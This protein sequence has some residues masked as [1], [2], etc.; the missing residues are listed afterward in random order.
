[1][2]KTIKLSLLVASATSIGIVKAIIPLSPAIAQSQAKI[3]VVT[4]DVV[5]ANSHIIEGEEGVVVIDSLLT[6]DGGSEVRKQVEATGKELLAV[7]VTHGHPD[8]YGGVTT[9]LDGLED[10]PV[11]ALEEVDNVIRRDDA[12]KGER[13]G[14]FGIDWPEKRTFPNTIVESEEPVQFGDI[15]L[16]PI[17]VGENESDYDS[18]WLLRQPDGDVA[19]VGDLVM[20]GM[21]AYTADAH[22]AR[23][24]TTLDSMKSELKD[25]VRI[26]PGH[27]KS[28][29][30][31]LLEP[32]QQYLNEFRN[33][34]QEIANCQPA[35]SEEQAEELQSRMVS[36]LGTDK[37]A[38]WI[39]EGATPVAEEIAQDCPN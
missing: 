27:G 20:E 14:N 4:G 24:L 23:W 38:R 18:I 34:V 10:V 21:H 1:M 31:E 8:H 37:N 35:M 28:G 17:S 9:L 15:E 22:T 11:V 13:L 33:Q 26:Y 6:R 29:G 5:F 30:L 16:V 19:F 25:V 7:I 32:Q 2:K 36:Y 3:Q 39:L 12:S